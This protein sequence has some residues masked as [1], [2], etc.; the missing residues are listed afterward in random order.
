VRIPSY[1]SARWWSS[2]RKPL[3]LI[4]AALLPVAL[5]A[6]TSIALASQQ[7]T[8]EVNKRIQATA[9]VSAVFVGE[10]TSGLVTLVHSYATRPALVSASSAGTGDRAQRDAH[11]R[12]LTSVGQG[13]S[14]AF[15][16]DLHGTLISV[17]P[18][19]PAVIGRNFAQRDW[20]RGLKTSPGP[21]V[22]NAYRTA[23]AGHPL[24]IA[25]SD[26]LRAPDGRPVGIL[27]VIYSLDAVADFSRSIAQAQGIALTVTDRSGTLLSAGGGHGLTSV[28][29]DPRVAAARAGR[30]GLLTYAPPR[31]GGG[32]D[33]AELSA[34]APVTGSGWT[35]VASVSKK[36]A[37]AGLSRLRTTVLSI[38][39]VLVL[40]LLAGGGVV[41][42]ADRRRRETESQL[43]GRDRKLAR[44]LDST[45]EGFV[46]IDATGVITAWSSRAAALFGWS[47]AEVLGR[48]LVDTLIPSSQRT[49]HLRGQTHYSPGA[50]SAVV[51]KRIEVSA[52]HRDGHEVPVEL[53]VW[54]HEED[55]GFS[56]FVHDIT[57]R[58]ATQVELKAARDEAMAASRLK[59]EFLA[60][61]SHEIRTPMNGVIGMS[62]LLL[63]T[64]LDTEQ[65]DYAETVRSSADALLTVIDDILDFS[66]IEAGKLEVESVHFDLHHVIEES[67]ALLASKAEEAGL[68]LTCLID[69][70]L[71]VSVVGDPGRL[72]QVLLNL[73]GNAVK[74]TATG[75]VNVT[76]R[77]AAGALPGTVTVQISVAD[78]G[79]GMAPETLRHL[80]GAFTQADT[81]TTRRYGGT[82][83]G[84]AISRQ[85]VELMGGTLSVASELGAGSTFTAAIPFTS[86]PVTASAPVLD[87][88]GVRALIVDDNA[89]NQ[90]VLQEVLRGWGCTA[91]LADGA[92]EALVL[93]R[94]A[95]EA[96]PFEIILLDLN[97]PGIDGFGLA[98]AVRADPALPATPMV[99]L[100]SSAQRGG[101]ERAG[102][103]GIAAYLTKPVRSTQ[104][105]A[106]LSDVL[107]AEASD[108]PAQPGDAGQPGDPVQ[109]GDAGQPGDPVQPGD[110]GQPGDPVQ[111][112]AASGRV[113]AQRRAAEASQPLLLVEDNAVNRKVFMALL[114]RL[115]YRVDVAV[116]GAEAL[117]QLSERRYCAVLMDCQMP[118]LDGYAAT[119]ELRR[120]EGTGPRTPVIALTASAMASDRERCLAA[121]MDDYLTKPVNS[122]RLTTTLAYW[123]EGAGSLT[124]PQQ[125]PASAD[126]ALT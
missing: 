63:Q 65:R 11:L 95:A 107:G 8:A 54:P 9:A 93:L 5:L 71:P 118:V 2:W 34:Y 73:L 32:H 113:P 98:R 83:L 4:L 44:M 119:E 60:N 48:P 21:Y 36:T 39:A 29:S 78:S 108:R 58:V 31:R 20:F 72:R 47:T 87:L 59:S 23:L 45:D 25:V 100:T 22:S 77:P 117:S 53:G 69:P 96:T 28:A 122:E 102:Q 17:Q 80:F 79:I 82:G 18:P 104:L 38:T 6:M 88:T 121:G 105:R 126:R 94:E 43:R 40:V 50:E 52:L 1:G 33:G 89:T 13:I 101:A 62:G 56:A 114:S 109:P 46:S 42:R 111:P 49:A 74:F 81:S 30:A 91:A 16:T 51:G 115:G 24:V 12:S 27:A 123:L 68:E 66:K 19:A 37:F 97:M 7:V 116:N 90:R 85:L 84:L 41:G 64:N 110:A 103:A 86:R 112:A 76:A 75:E 67:A 10:Q 35:V 55:G 120:R 15:I 70:A 99:L 14:G 125:S 26:Y 106:A 57:D 61:M 92:E 124:G 3:A